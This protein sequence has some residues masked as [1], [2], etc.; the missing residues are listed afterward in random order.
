L[1]KIPLYPPFTKGEANQ[2]RAHPPLRKGGRGGISKPK[3]PKSLLPLTAE[4][5]AELPELPEGWGWVKLEAIVEEGPINGYSPQAVKFET[6]TKAITLTATTSGKFDGSYFKY[7][8][9]AIPNESSLWL[10]FGDILIQR[11]NTIEY[12]GVPAI[13]KG[14]A[15][16]FIYPDLIMKIRVVQFVDADYTVFSLREERARSW[17][18][19]RA[20]G[21]AGSMPKINHATLRSLPIPICSNLEQQQ[22]VQE[23]ESKL[24][25]V[26]QLD[27]TITTSLQQAEALRQSI[28]KKA[29]SGQLVPQDP[30]DEP[31]S[32]LLV[33]IKA[34]RA[35]SQMASSG[36]KRRNDV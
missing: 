18:R 16:Q 27:Q 2:H 20:V 28:L 6:G 1:G 19:G 29:F 13:Y 10:R 24:S 25:E 32:E 11:G 22:I 33:R 7:I 15:N 34:E 3:L 9:E 4:E 17:L 12:V 14:H 30:N 21:A 35:A 23:L 36:R 31:A 5:L 8:D 26:D